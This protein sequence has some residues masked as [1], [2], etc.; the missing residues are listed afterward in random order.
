[1]TTSYRLKIL[2]GTLNGV[3]YALAQGDTLFH[4][5]SH[6]DLVEGRAAQVLGSAE[7]AFYLPQDLPEAAFLIKVGPEAESIQ[8]GE[9]DHPDQ[10]W[11][12][13]PL[14]LLQVTCAAGIYFAARESEQVW[15]RQVLDFMPPLALP[16]SS[17]APQT[18]ALKAHNAHRPLGRRHFGLGLALIAMAAVL[19]AWWTWHHSPGARL[20]GLVS[21][22]KGAPDDYQIISGSDGRL[23]AFTDAR[24][25]LAWGERAS[26]R[27]QRRNDAYVLRWAE[28]TRLE[29]EMVRAG[30]PIVVVRLN[31][32]SR[33]EVV[34]L[35]TVNAS[36]REAVA[37]VLAVKAPY[38][39]DTA[40]VNGVSDQALIEL[41]Q[42]ELR[43]LGISSRSEPRGSQVSVV[44]DVFLDDSS[45]HAM[46]EMAARFHQHWGRRRITVQ[47]RLWD[48][49]LQ[50]RS[51]RYAPGQL[52]SVGQGQWKYAGASDG[53]ASAAP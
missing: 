12:Y 21:V 31:D 46:G 50:G 17:I 2:S 30:L 20:K 16:S 29:Q 49:L 3:E 27:L 47:V 38:A 45:L 24:D 22:L 52:L 51:Y 33:P 14:A 10:P 36:V 53:G 39:R 4:I 35:G 6:R 37:S 11:Q 41:A 34:L 28:A 32:P 5:G 23:Y 7:N 44:N 15:P 43:G 8:L 9:R 48:D 19:A 40:R 26:R 25:G 13:R 18:S 42:A 1:M